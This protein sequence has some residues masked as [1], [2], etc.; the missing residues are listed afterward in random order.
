MVVFKKRGTIQLI[1][2]QNNKKMKKRIL[3]VITL[4]L[5]AFGITTTAHASALNDANF[6][7]LNDINTINKIEVRGNVELYIS[8][9]ETDQVKVYNQYY[10]ESAL[11]QNKSGVL[12]ISSYTPEKLVVWITSND[13]HSVSAYDNAVVKSFGKLS[14][15][16]FNVDL[17]NNA[18][19]KL[20]LDAFN[21]N[22][23]LTDR[24]TADL[25]GTANDFN[26]KHSTSSTVN[27]F[28]FAA[29]NYNDSKIY[30]PA[31]MREAELVEIY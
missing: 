16:E 19:A 24:A 26:L 12:C 5:V 1:E 6:T 18:S 21:A 10:A 23:T 27:K 8:D 14:K 4:V 28:N 2:Y 25:N 29:V 15:I 31:E 17:H 7:I 20:D 9:G 11:I 3:T 30:S 22:V 13:L